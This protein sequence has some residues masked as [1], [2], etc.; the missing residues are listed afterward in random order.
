[1]RNH[2]IFMMCP[3]HTLKLRFLHLP[4]LWFFKKASGNWFCMLFSFG[5]YLLM[6]QCSQFYTLLCQCSL[7]SVVSTFKLF[8]WLLATILFIVVW[9]IKDELTLRKSLSWNSELLLQCA[10]LV[11]VPKRLKVVSNRDLKTRMICC[12]VPLGDL[13][14]FSLPTYFFRYFLCEFRIKLVM[15]SSFH[16]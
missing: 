15:W 16:S 1:M 2:P 12:E 9:L 10:Q 7:H 5:C 13:S 6:L 4:D 11:P 3:E 14:W 8:K